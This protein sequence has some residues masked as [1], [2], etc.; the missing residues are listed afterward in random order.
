MEGFEMTGIYKSKS[1]RADGN[2]TPRA[3]LLQGSTDELSTRS[4]GPSS[5]HLK[6]P[7][8][9]SKDF[10]DEEAP[11]RHML[12]QFFAAAS[13]KGWL[14]EILAF[15][16][17][18]VALI[19]IVITLALHNGS[20]LP[21]WPF[22]IS[23][24]ALISVF[25]VIL[26]G[27]MMVP[28]ASGTLH[29]LHVSQT[30]LTFRFLAISQLKFVWYTNPEPLIHLSRFDLASR[31][32]WGA[33]RLLLTLRGRHLAAL[34]AAITILAIA[35]DP[36]IQQ[37]I[38]YRPCPQAVPSLQASVLRTNNYTINSNTSL[39]DV[40]AIDA[41]MQA[42]LYEGVYESFSAI[43][44]TC[45]TGNCTFPHYRTVGMCSA[46]NEISNTINATCSN[47][48]D[49][50]TCNWTLPSGLTLNLTEGVAMRMAPAYD[51]TTLSVSEVITFTDLLD[52]DK[53]H[54][55]NFTDGI[56]GT[57][58]DVMAVQC[59]L[60][61]CVRTYGMD[62]VENQN[63]EVLLD[64]SEMVQQQANSSEMVQQLIYGEVPFVMANQSQ[65][66]NADAIAPY[67]GAPMP[68]LLDG[69]Y[70]DATSFTEPNTTNIWPVKGLLPN[71]ATAYLPNSCVFM[72]ENTFG[73]E[74]YLPLFLQGNVSAIQGVPNYGNPDWMVQLYDNGNATFQTVNATWA[75]IADSITMRVR[76][77]GDP[78]NSEPAAGVVLQTDTCVSV[79]WPWLNFPAAL[80]VLTLVFLLATIVQSR[81]H[82]NL[83]IWKG[84][85]LALLFHGM[86]QDLSDRY[87]LVDQLDEME[88]KANH[89]LVQI[90]DIEGGLRFVD[91]ARQ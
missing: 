74:D 72:W 24:N 18:I 35:S 64:T 8:V 19:A 90:R 82:T 34:G 10:S 4:D 16:L 28:V 43:T 50:T 60:F 52:Y 29:A 41:P 17:A 13:P 57:P 32:P 37:V 66:G 3:P 11:Q 48:T 76:K 23:I 87:R 15:A 59:S 73:L 63:T 39:S 7:I 68:C 62:V 84:S 53:T 61:P 21:N 20:T 45:P 46:C 79:Q 56:Y 14:P 70:Y 65:I 88:E 80:L 51:T 26:K 12:R 81:R 91:A 47:T 75:A 67:I 78:S 40:S 86:D 89:M 44:P 38:K 31:G 77:S 33:G 5:T 55:V 22:Q 69:T 1:Q 83:H 54:I 9:L 42:A 30:I 36:F 2:L 6:E 49:A 85:P 58:S 27:A 25:G 71:D